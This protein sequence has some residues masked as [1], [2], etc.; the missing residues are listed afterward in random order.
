MVGSNVFISWFNDIQFSRY[1]NI[2]NVQSMSEFFDIS[3]QTESNIIL[4]SQI[5]DSETSDGLTMVFNFFSS[6]NTFSGRDI[7]PK[8]SFSHF[9]DSKSGRDGTIES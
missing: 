4:I 6:V 9:L 2:S 3:F 1:I 8:T 5:L 7:S